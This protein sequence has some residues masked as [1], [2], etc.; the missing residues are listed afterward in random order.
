MPAGEWFYVLEGIGGAGKTTVAA[1]VARL[2]ELDGY[3]VVCTRQPGGT[4]VGKALRSL[5]LDPVYGEDIDPGAAIRRRPP[6]PPAP[7]PA[8][9]G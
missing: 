2:L 9:A 8:G 5:L 3:T 4:E 6:H 1:E 7:H